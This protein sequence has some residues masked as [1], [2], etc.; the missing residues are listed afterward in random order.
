MSRYLIS[1]NFIGWEDTQNDN[2][3]ASAHI[4]DYISLFGLF[5]GIKGS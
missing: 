1:Y 5:Q 3:I 2:F 4:E